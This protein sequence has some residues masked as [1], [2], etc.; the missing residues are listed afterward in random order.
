MALVRIVKREGDSIF[1]EYV[2]PIRVFLTTWNL[3][4]WEDWRYPLGYWA[5]SHLSAP[6]YVPPSLDE[7]WEKKSFQGMKLLDDEQKWRIT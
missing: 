7:V 4:D 3:F 2:S 6:S 5:G 1:A